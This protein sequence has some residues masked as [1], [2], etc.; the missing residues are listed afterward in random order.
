MAATASQPCTPDIETRPRLASLMSLDSGDIVHISNE[1]C[2]VSL[3]PYFLLIETVL[4]CSSV[5]GLGQ[6]SAARHCDNSPELSWQNLGF[7]AAAGRGH[8]SS[9]PDLHSSMRWI[10]QGA[11]WWSFSLD[12]LL[13]A[14]THFHFT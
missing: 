6:V 7:A 2:C 1:C 14:S 9:S 3:D 11:P 4:G 10:R 5:A 8:N 12:P 13:G